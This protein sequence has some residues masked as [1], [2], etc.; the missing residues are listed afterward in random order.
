MEKR[1]SRKLSKDVQ[2]ELRY[3]CIKMLQRGKKQKEVVEALEVSRASVVR[4]WRSYKNEGLKGLQLKKRGRSQG[5]K[6]RLTPDQ[7][8]GIQKMI[9]D[10]SP[11]QLKL[12]FALWTRKAVQ[13]AILQHHEVKL[14]IRTV[15]EYLSRWGFTPQKPIKRA[16][17]QQPE[18]IKKWLDEEYPEIARR[19]KK[20]KAEILW[21][22]ETGLS[23][24]DNRG[25]GYSPRGRTPIVYS[26]GARFST[27]MVSAI[28]NEGLL[29]FM[30][31][32]GGLKAG[33]FINFLRRL[34]K[35][36]ERKIFLIVDNL[37]VH[38]AIKVGDWLETHKENIEIFFLPPYSPEQNPDEYLNHDVKTHVRQLPAPRSGSELI[39]SLRSYMRHLQWETTKIIRFFNNEPVCYAKAF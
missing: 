7:E 11:N 26:P 17:E 32:Q 36:T 2:Y 21:G 10:K 14:P 24:E 13:E 5:E 3:R 18:R 37:R 20:E 38:H 8:K 4:W 28:T 31:Y 1:D 33:T 12:P 35:D 39:N 25:R 15:G 23:S 30:V 9:I 19:A 16:Y 34:I 29:R 27:S 6:R 22:D